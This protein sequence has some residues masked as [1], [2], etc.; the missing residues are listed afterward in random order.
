MNFVMVPSMAN[1][2]KTSVIGRLHAT[3]MDAAGVM[4]AVNVLMATVDLAVFR[5]LVLH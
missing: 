3:D 1:F 5:N 2:V 4:G